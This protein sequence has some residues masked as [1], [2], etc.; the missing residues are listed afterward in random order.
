MFQS[1]LLCLSDI[2]PTLDTDVPRLDICDLTETS[3]FGWQQPILVDCEWRP[4]N[5]FDLSQWQSGFINLSLSCFP[6]GDTTILPPTEQV[7]EFS[8]CTR[9]KIRR[10]R[11]Y[12]V[13]ISSPCRTVDGSECEFWD[14]LEARDKYG[15]Y[16]V[17]LLDCDGRISLPKNQ[18]DAIAAGDNT[19]GGGPIGYTFSLNNTPHIRDNSGLAEWY[20]QLNIAYNGVICYTV[21]PGLSSTLCV[22]SFTDDNGNP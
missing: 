8:R 15:S 7:I 4:T 13:D 17:I 22:R 10:N 19:A 3:D 14:D 16:R 1:F 20:T 11:Q 18:L 2:C 5:I 12:P 21:I 6:P 9:Q